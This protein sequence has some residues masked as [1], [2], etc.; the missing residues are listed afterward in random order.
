MISLDY[1]NQ[2]TVSLWGDEAFASILAQKN[3][4]EITTTVARD[5][6]PPLHYLLLHFWMLLFGKSEIA[7]RAF[8]FFLFL[9]LGFV[10][11]R[12]TRDLFDERVARFA[13]IL[14]LLNP[15]LFLYAFEARM[16]MLLALTTAASMWFFMTKRWLL[17][18]L[19]TVAALY[20]H[21]FSIFVVLVQIISY[22]VAN[23]HLIRQ[24]PIKILKSSFLRALFIVTILY[25]PWLPA[26]YGQTTQVATDFW[27]PRPKFEDLW[28]LYSHFI[29]GSSKIP[30]ES[31]VLMTGLLLLVLRGFRRNPDGLLYLWL[32]LPAILTYFLSQIGRPLFFD[33]Y[34][35][36]SASALPI[37]LAS[38][39]ASNV[40][41]KKIALPLLL[42]MIIGLLFINLHSFQNP[43]K[44]PF[45]ELAHFIQTTYSKDKVVINYYTNALH[46]FELK[47]YDI[48]VKIY[49]PEGPLPF[50]VGTAL[51]DKNDV[52]ESLPKDPIVL[53][54][55]SGDLGRIKITGYQEI[56]RR[57]FRDLYLLWFMKNKDFVVY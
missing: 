36:I 26:L 20:T 57:Q 41:G 34:L 18:V 7:I 15:F 16:Y 28:L 1:M 5:T 51:I 49:S 39:R 50:W 2:L 19:A 11:Y 54:M 12:A 53:I 25:L 56:R 9:L 14:T 42:L 45:R 31:I 3:L 52:L 8:P 23:F 4:L 13:L 46:Y 10:V 48:N 6:S 55:A 24:K 32:F 29:A 17:Y 37:L 43:V 30:I 21:H 35:I 27:L 33:R 38:Q 47:H 22:A 40:P 44:Q